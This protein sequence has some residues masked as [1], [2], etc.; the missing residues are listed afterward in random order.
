MPHTAASQLVTNE[1]DILMATSSD[2]IIRKT[3]AG[4]ITAWNPGAERL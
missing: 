1:L 2:A 4:I 3:S